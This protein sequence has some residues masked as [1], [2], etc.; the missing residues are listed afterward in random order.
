[1]TMSTAPTTTTD[2][3]A[4]ARGLSIV[5]GGA[6]VVLSAL[7]WGA[8][9]LVAAAVGAGLSV[10]NVFVLTRFARQAVAVAAAG[11]PNTAIVRLTSALGAKTIVLLTVVWALSKSSRLAV[12]PLALGLLV[13][14][15]CLLAAGLVTGLR[16]GET[17]E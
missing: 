10:L 4:R 2:L 13:T 9:G 3:E 1:M 7:A 15:F 12:L 6:V 5:V 11:G 8:S 14:A 17:T 16:D